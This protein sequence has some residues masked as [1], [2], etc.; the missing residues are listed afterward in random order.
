MKRTGRPIPPLDTA[1]LE[2]LALRYVERFATTRGKLAAYLAR[3]IRERGWDG[4]PADPASV[5]ERFAELGYVND[6]LFAEAKASSMA[7]R[8]LG[9]RRVNQALRHAGVIGEDADAVAPQVEARR[10]ETAVAFARRRRIGPFAAVAADRPKQAKHV[11]AM[12][13]AG[14]SPDLAWRIARMAPGES[15]A[16]I[17]EEEHY[18]VDPFQESDG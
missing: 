15:T 5:A 8:G 6:R 14:H 16:A 11:A 12:V 13:R 10:G 7:R 2:R 3:K 9:A 1:S 18:C 4:A 17:A